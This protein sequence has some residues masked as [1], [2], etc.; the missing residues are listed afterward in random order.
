MFVKLYLQPDA[1]KVF[2]IEDIISIDPILTEDT[3]VLG[4]KLRLANQ[5]EDIDLNQ[6]QV[7]RLTQMLSYQTIRSPWCDPEAQFLTPLNR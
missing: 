6:E 7:H 2:R 1:Y 5:Q 4:Y 3:T